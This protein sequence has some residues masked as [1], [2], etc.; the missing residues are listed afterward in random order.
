VSVRVSTWAWQQ[1]V[2]GAVRGNRLLVL[3]ALADQADDTGSCFPGQKSLA[4]KC[5][6]SERALQ[7]HLS[8]LEASGHVERQRRH[9]SNGTRSSDLYK[10]PLPADFAGGRGTNPQNLRSLPAD[11]DQTYPQ[12]LRGKVNRQ[13]ETSGEP[14]VPPS[15]SA[16]V[17]SHPSARKSYDRA[18]R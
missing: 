9:R 12:N 6:I 1:S 8:A 17:I 15:K 11:S 3:L 16:K 7:G 2:R 10:L 5:G 13:K 18:F 4:R 14:G